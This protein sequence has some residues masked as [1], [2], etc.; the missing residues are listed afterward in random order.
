MVHTATGANLYTPPPPRK[1]RRLMTDLV[2]WL[3]D[4]GELHPVLVAGLAHL[5][6]VRVHPF[7]DGNGRSARLLTLLCLYRAG[8]D[9]ERLM[10][11]SEYYD[12]NRSSYYHGVRIGNEEGADVTGWLAYFAAG[13]AA[14]LRKAA[15]QAASR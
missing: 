1:M 15:A 10:S 14:Q 9:R 2:A 11:I 4:P 3:A 13:L 7:L 8:Y 12:R 6:L 5:E